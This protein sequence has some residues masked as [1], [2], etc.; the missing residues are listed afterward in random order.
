MNG[1]T[2]GRALPYQKIPQMR[3][4]NRH[5]NLTKLMVAALALVTSGIDHAPPPDNP[6][7]APEP[8][9]G[10]W[11]ELHE[12][13]VATAGRGDVDLLLLG[14]SITSLWM[15]TARGLWDRHYAPRKAANFGI[16]G[17][18]TQHLLWRL[19][20]GELEGIR[21]KVVVVMIGTNNIPHDAEDQVVEGVE[22]VVDRIRRKLPASK[23]LLLGILPRG[24]NQDPYQVTT[25]PDPRVARINLKLARLEDEPAITYLDIGPALLNDEGR[26]VQVIEPDF[27]HLSRKGYRIWADAMEPTLWT[28]MQDD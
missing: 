7:V 1:S 15:T 20:H 27:L 25:A 14:D 9:P 13:F 16:G 21:P 17:D 12:S 6:A 8:R 3:P 22:A 5:A 2:A 26:L 19:D 10:S 18:H 23:I 24:L 28:L 11:R 4:A